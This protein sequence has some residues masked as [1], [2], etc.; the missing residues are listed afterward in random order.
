MLYDLNNFRFNWFIFATLVI[1]V[2]CFLSLQG[3][4]NS[5]I[6]DGLAD[7]VPQ[8][9]HALIKTRRRRIR[10]I[11]FWRYMITL[12]SRNRGETVLFPHIHIE[13]LSDN[14]A[15]QRFVQ[16]RAKLERRHFRARI[17]QLE[18]Y[19]FSHSQEIQELVEQ[20]EEKIAEVKSRL[21]LTAKIKV[22]WRRLKSALVFQYQSMRDMRRELRL[23]LVILCISIIILILSIL[24]DQSGYALLSG[25][26]GACA[27]ALG[28]FIVRDNHK[29]YKEVTEQLVR[30]GYQPLLDY[31]WLVESNPSVLYPTVLDN[32]DWSVFSGLA[33]KYQRKYSEFL[34]HQRQKTLKNKKQKADEQG[35]QLD[36]LSLFST[37]QS[38]NSFSAE[39]FAL[40]LDEDDEAELRRLRGKKNGGRNF[41][42]DFMPLFKAFVILRFMDIEPSVANV[43]R[44]LCGNPYLLVKLNFKDNRL[45]SERVIYR[46]DQVM[47]RYG[48]WKEAFEMGVFNN[49]KL[50]VIDPRKEKYFGADTTHQKACSARGKKKKKCVYCPLLADCPHPQKTDNTAAT[51]V[52]KKTEYHHAHKVALGN[53]LYSELC[54]AFKVFK[55]NTNDAKTFSPLV[56]MV[57]EKFPEFDF[58]HI[59]V[60]GIFD[61]KDCYEAAR[62]HYPQARLLPSKINP[63]SRKDKKI[64]QR[65]IVLVNKRGQAI[66]INRQ[67]MVFIT[68]D[69]KNRTYLWGCPF[70]HPDVTTNRGFTAKEK[71]QIIEE[72]KYSRDLKGTA[73]RHG[74]TPKVL[75][76]WRSRMRCARDEKLD[77]RG[78]RGLEDECPLKAQCCPNAKGGRI[79]RTKA[80]EYPFIDWDLPQ[81]SYQRR[82]IM[83]LR[84]ANERIISRLKENLSGDK[85][86]KQNDFN[87]EAHIAKSLLAQHIFAAVAFA[88]ERPEAIRRIKTFHSV[89]QRAA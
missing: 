58:S 25:P 67:K 59:L 42:H 79:F 27:F 6:N 71:Y 68:R 23:S 74:I 28:S 15:F 46:F 84:L 73:K 29:K 33:R 39:E 35:T 75:T 82:V 48:L 10:R 65:G 14:R 18:N 76:A 22:A 78:L 62:T 20:Y 72:W 54:L 57:K 4:N 53:L 61:E 85:L 81:Y 40:G 32:F 89:F 50:G 49:I 80:E 66:C 43:I 12:I 70:Y 7:M 64:H 31:G 37:H 30:S 44:T 13:K 3:W 24:M 69:L 63:R 1:I 86:F 26:V 47:S 51:L 45:P 83:A 11:V 41:E 8:W 16:K 5:R 9:I 52:K 55:G 17:R 77:P 60:D 56:E 87:V 19:L 2:L 21:P 38:D 34:A 36:F 88:L